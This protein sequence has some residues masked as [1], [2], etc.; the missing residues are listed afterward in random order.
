MQTA[1]EKQAIDQ[2]GSGKSTQTDLRIK[3]TADPAHSEITFKVKHLMITHV[4]GV[5]TDYTIEAIS[6][7]ERF[8]N[9]SVLFTGKTASI[10]TGNE[11]RD[12]H[13]Q[14]AEFFD[15]EKYPD[16]RFQSTG[17]KRSDNGYNM[18]GELTIRNITNKITLYVKLLG[19]QQ[20][21]WGKTRAGFSVTGKINR[22]HF[23]LDWNAPLEGGG[24]LISNEVIILCE[25]Q[26]VKADV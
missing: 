21:P 18:T 11:Q 1:K 10:S 14:S 7:G 13:L 6:E 26:M 5:L 17:F 3:W 23:K 20:D 24:V 16:L 15:V 19:I 9:V 12:K 8:N 2:K 25:V 4:T 22:Q